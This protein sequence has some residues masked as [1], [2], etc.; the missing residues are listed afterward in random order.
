MKATMNTTTTFFIVA[1]G[2]MT[3]IF[4]GIHTF[5]SITFSADVV[6]K[7]IEY[8]NAIDAAH[9]LKAC[10]EGSDDTITWD[11]PG[12]TD[13]Y[14][15]C[16]SKFPGLSKLKYEYRIDDV[17]TKITLAESPGYGDEETKTSHA[18]Y[19]NIV[20]QDGDVHIGRVYVKTG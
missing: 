10:I 12:N 8:L 17:E 13:L 7:D 15:L 9:L 11:E 4:F 20:M 18:I 3:F 19:I 1:F 5:S 16:S 14:Y 6:A 2:M